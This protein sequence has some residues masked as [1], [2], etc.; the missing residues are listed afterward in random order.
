MENLKDIFQIPNKQERYERLVEWVASE[1]FQNK[2][3]IL[4]LHGF[5]ERRKIRKNGKKLL[6]HIIFSSDS[7]SSAWRGPSIGVKIFEQQGSVWRADLRFIKPLS[8]LERIIQ[9]EKDV[10]LENF[11]NPQRIRIFREII[12]S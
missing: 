10:D 1:V 5:S 6:A 7:E 9:L 3:S 8:G 4:E 12:S 11:M 2:I